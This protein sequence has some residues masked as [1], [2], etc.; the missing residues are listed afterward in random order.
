MFEETQTPL[1]TGPIF[2][3]DQDSDE[4]VEDDYSADSWP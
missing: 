1:L 2:T 3:D 4:D